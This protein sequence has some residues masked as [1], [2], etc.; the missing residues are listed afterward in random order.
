MTN[1]PTLTIQ[2]ARNLA[3]A[4]QGLLA[5]PKYPAEK[6][7]LLKAIRRIHALQIDTI[8]V[9]ERAPY[10]TIYSRVGSYPKDWLDELLAEGQL[11]EYWAHANCF[12]PMEDYPLFRRKMLERATHWWQVSDWVNDHQDMIA[13]VIETIKEKEV[14]AGVDMVQWA[15]AW[16]LRH[17]AVASVIPGAKNAAQLK[18]NAKAA[19]TGY[20]LV[21]HIALWLAPTL[22]GAYF[23]MRE[24]IHWNESLRDEMKETN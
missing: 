24:G 6:P 4:A 17:P 15:L 18:V 2:S 8:N 23:M 14:P 20:T 16:C 12:I 5:P 21:L 22:L 1:K 3:L 9:V 7:D 13:F 11:F 19:A 10:H